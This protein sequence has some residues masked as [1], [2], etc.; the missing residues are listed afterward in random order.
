[1]ANNRLKS[2]SRR[3]GS[4]TRGQKMGL[5]AKSTKRSSGR[6]TAAAAS[7]SRAKTSRPV[8][9]STGKRATAR[10][11]GVRRARVAASAR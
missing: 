4:S 7:R 1:M 3:Q 5:G 2:A 11:T 8:A 9:I 10:R 6:R